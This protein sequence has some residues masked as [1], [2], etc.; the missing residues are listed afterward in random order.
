MLYLK[1]LKKDYLFRQKY[2]K[3]SINIWKLKG[4]I[5]NKILPPK[6]RIKNRELLSKIIKQ[7]NIYETKIKNKC[8]LTGRSRGV[9]KEFGISRIIFKRLADDGKLLSITKK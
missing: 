4:I 7:N 9:I 5:N 6:T 3:Y 1:R 2:Y 8:L